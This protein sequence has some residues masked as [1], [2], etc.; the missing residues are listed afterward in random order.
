MDN[1]CNV[2]FKKFD[3]PLYDSSEEFSIT[4]MN[5]MVSGT[6]RVHFCSFCGHL[7][8]NELPDLKN[9]YAH[10]YEIN[11][12]GENSDQVY[13]VINGRPVFRSDHQAEVL[14]SKMPY[15]TG[16][17]ILDYGCGKASTVKKLIEMQTDIEI[18]LFDVTDK[19]LKY[20]E[21]FSKLPNWSLHHIDSSWFNL[22]DVVL[23]FYS[24]EHVSDL[25]EV[26][27]DVRFLLK[28]N[29][30]F[31]FVVPNVYTNMADF[32]VADH[33]NHFCHSSIHTLLK[34]NGFGN[35]EIDTIS[36]DCAFVVTAQLDNEAFNIK[37]KNPY[38]V[39]TTYLSA[40]EISQFWI[41]TMARIRNISTEMKAEDVYAIYGAGF[42]GNLIAFLLSNM[43]Q[44]H[45]FIDQNPYIQGSEIHGKVVLSPEALPPEITHIIVGLNP[46]KAQSIID[47]I[48]IWK[49]R[50]LRYIYL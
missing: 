23:S 20:W 4:T 46:Y 27:A 18:Y 10:E 13:A 33:I 43:D 19:Y 9:F 31:Y 41:K 45:C 12:D 32:I 22:M 14:L 29:G 50:K 38:D 8:T 26:L 16:Y 40:C 11:I 36:H 21:R 17:R 30:I 35:I 5:R 49:S 15:L 1:C 44:I 2:C 3:Q 34:R 6:T 39:E 24:L 25:N 42:Y 28:P 48:A 7:Q 47:S 37:E